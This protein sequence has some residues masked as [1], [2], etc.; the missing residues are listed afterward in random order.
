[1][2]EELSEEQ[3]EELRLVQAEDPAFFAASLEEVYIGS[4]GL[5]A[6]WAYRKAHELWCAGAR[7][8]ALLIS[9][10][11]RR[12]FGVE[13]HPGARIG[14]HFMIDHGMGV[15]I[16]ETCIIGDN[17]KIFQGVTLGCRGASCKGGKR[18]PTLEDNVTVGV[19]ALVLGNITVGAGA[20]VG[21]GAV[22]IKDVAAKDVVAGVPARS[23]RARASVDAAGGGVG[24]DADADAEGAGRNA[25]L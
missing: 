17:C 6:V 13:I 21:A 8:E 3:L 19:S 16:G 23:V 4:P 12:D 14:K 18:H 10:E 9:Q 25:D 5:K 2:L 1:M 15:V 11:A 22:V 7:E 20:H 24:K